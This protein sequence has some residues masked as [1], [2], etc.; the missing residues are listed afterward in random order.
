MT[1]NE[2]APATSDRAADWRVA[3]RVAGRVGEE[4]PEV[5]VGN[6]IY[7]GS[8][9]P[10]AD[11]TVP[12]PSVVRG[13]CLPSTRRSCSWT[14]KSSSLRTPPGLNNGNQAGG[15]RDLFVQSLAAALAYRAKTD[16]EAAAKHFVGVQKLKKL[17]A[18]IAA[19]QT[20]VDQLSGADPARI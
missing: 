18:N 15:E 14:T 13:R 19:L 1:L 8:G 5:I 20:Q 11:L 3:H 16:V 9:R 4:L 17:R 6:L 10:V 2:A 12:T 7:A